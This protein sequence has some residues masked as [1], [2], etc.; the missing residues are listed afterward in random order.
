MYVY[1]GTCDVCTSAAM[2]RCSDVGPNIVKWN[3]VSMTL[4]RLT[5]PL[6]YLKRQVYTKWIATSE[7]SAIIVRNTVDFA[8]QVLS[9]LIQTS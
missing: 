6:C 3:Q 4:N 8:V 9:P 7:S 1:D 2:L 5:T